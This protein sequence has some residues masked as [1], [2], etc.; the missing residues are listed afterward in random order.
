MNMSDHDQR[1]SREYQAPFIRIRGRI[2][3]RGEVKWSP[4]LRT[5]K[6]PSKDIEHQ[7]VDVR[8][9]AA[10]RADPFAIALLDYRG[11]QLAYTAVKPQF[12]AQNQ[13]SATFV[14]RLPFHE[15]IHAIQLLRNGKRASSMEVPTC[16]PYFTL[17]HPR[18]DSFID[19]QGVL[20]LHWSDHDSEHPLTYFVRYSHNGKDW[21]RP[22]VNLK[23]NDFY[24]DLRELPGGPRCVVQV[25]ATNG[26][27]TSFVQ[28]RYFDVAIK[29][30]EILLGETAGPKLFA[31]GYSRESGPITGDQIAWID[32][33]GSVVRRGGSLDVRT[34]ERGI[35]RLSVRV[36]GPNDTSRTE[37]AGVY[38]S[39]TGLLVGQSTT[40]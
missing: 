14:T 40:L 27:R 22:G 24:L 36:E 4:C 32:G 3:R 10:T 23:G 11:E 33:S 34:L 13:E 37:L 19:S 18:E 2:S 38:D 12:F 35:Y 20:H 30:L 15:D 21:L 17:L 6:G 1:Q 29:Q 16:R 8:R 25:L 28:T 26:F 9:A 7:L 39:T 5:E 31:Q